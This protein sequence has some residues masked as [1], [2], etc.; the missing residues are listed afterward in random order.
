MLVGI[1]SFPL[2]IGDAPSYDFDNGFRDFFIAVADNDNALFE[3][4]PVGECIGYFE[5]DKIGGQGVQGW[6]QPEKES[7]CRKQ[8]DVDKE[9]GGADADAVE[10]LDN[11][12]DNVAAAGAASY[13]VQCTQPDAVQYAAGDTA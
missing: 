3:I 12:A 8:H 7:S 4:K 6:F 13:P 9:S 11:S 5:Y 10:F 1:G 2:N